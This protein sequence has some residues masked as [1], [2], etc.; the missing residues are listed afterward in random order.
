M[1]H[2]VEKFGL[3]TKIAP[4]GANSVSIYHLFIV[5]AS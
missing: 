3:K 4:F 2:K 5:A 1:I